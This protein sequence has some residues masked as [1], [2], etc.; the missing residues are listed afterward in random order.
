[1]SKSFKDSKNEKI[2]NIFKSR[3]E[4]INNE[5]NRIKQLLLNEDVTE[6]SLDIHIKFDKTKFDFNHRIWRT[7]TNSDEFSELKFVDQVKKEVKIKT[8]L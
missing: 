4:Q 5:L 1:M 2:N 7:L 6:V 3:K 8:N